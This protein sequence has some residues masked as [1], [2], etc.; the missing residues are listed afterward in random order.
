MRTRHLVAPDR[1]NI[2]PLPTQAD[3]LL[4]IVVCKCGLFLLLATVFLERGQEPRAC[5]AL[6]LERPYAPVLAIVPNKTE[7]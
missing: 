6:S 3:N 5:A 7:F 2:D 4:N 1:K